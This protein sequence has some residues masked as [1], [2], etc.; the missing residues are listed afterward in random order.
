MPSLINNPRTVESLRE[1]ITKEM[2]KHGDVWENVSSYAIEVKA[3]MIGDPVLWQGEEVEHP[4]DENGDIFGV[5]LTPT[6]QTEALDK[7]FLKEWIP[8]YFTLWT[9]ERVYF[10]AEYDSHQWCDSL[11][12]NPCNEATRHVGGH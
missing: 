6:E 1:V 4:H 7:P 2:T 5:K 9:K 8:Y 11:P 10:P 3:D 12:R